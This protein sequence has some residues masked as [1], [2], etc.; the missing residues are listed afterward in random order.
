M[1]FTDHTAVVTGSTSGIGRAI[2]GALAAE[3]ARVL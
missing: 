2:A 1:R 3:G